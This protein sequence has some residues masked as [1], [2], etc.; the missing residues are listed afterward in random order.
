[1]ALIHYD[2]FSA[3]LNC[4]TRITITLPDISRGPLRGKSLDEIYRPGRKF[5]T[6]YL[7]HGGSGDSTTWYRNT[8]L[9]LYLNEKNMMSVSIDAPETFYCD[10]VYGRPYFTYLTEEIPRLVQT[11]FP[12]SP[13]RKDN[14]ILGFSMGAHGA[15]KAALRCPERFAAVMAISG[16]K[17]QVKM[18]ELAEQRGIKA[19]FAVIDAAFGPKETVAGSDNDLIYLARALAESGKEPPMLYT[20]CGTEDYGLPLCREF[21]EYLNSLGLKNQ[22]ITQPGIHDYYFANRILKYTLDEL[23]QIEDPLG[24]EHI[25]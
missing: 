22:F 12:S 15:M 4:A 10:M 16:A 17:D 18:R 13:D 23:F 24:S 19:S 14:F 20:A 8:Q 9:E 6:L 11:L 2:Y 25:R 5:P 7:C 1:M 21:H 3:V